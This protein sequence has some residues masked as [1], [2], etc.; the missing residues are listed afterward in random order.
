MY[1]RNLETK[2]VHFLGVMLAAA[3][4]VLALGFLHLQDGADTA[5]RIGAFYGVTLFLFAALKRLRRTDVL[6]IAGMLAVGGE[7]V[8]SGHELVPLAW[9]LAGVA[10]AA[11]PIWIA[12]PRET[13]RRRAADRAQ[14]P[15]RAPEV[16][17]QAWVVEAVG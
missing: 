15:R 6:A 7:L 9:S 2:I 4:A 13:Q 16:Q 11:A 1:D 14:P 3:T 5:S 17:L 10:L 12:R 8:R